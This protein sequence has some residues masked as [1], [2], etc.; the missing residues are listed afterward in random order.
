MNTLEIFDSLSP[1]E[2]ES[3]EMAIPVLQTLRRWMI[4]TCKQ[5]GISYI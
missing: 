4:Y 2:A 1:G 3:R 5:I